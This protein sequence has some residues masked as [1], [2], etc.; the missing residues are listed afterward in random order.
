MYNM[1]IVNPA[2]AGSKKYLFWS[3]IQKAM[4]NIEDAPT[5]LLFRTPVG[6]NVGFRFVFYLR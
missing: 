6:D 5:F 3:F 1:N 4:G 2:Y